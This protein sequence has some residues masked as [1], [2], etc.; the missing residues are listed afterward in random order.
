MDH[1]LRH[2]DQVA[3]NRN[4]DGRKTVT[5]DG[6]RIEIE[7]PCDQ[8]GSFDPQLIAKYQ[9]RFAGFDDKII[10]MCARGMSTREIMDH[11]RDLYGIDGSPD[12]INTITEAVLED[13]AAS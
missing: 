8:A 7:A 1:H 9:R 13:V 5:T 12:L 2:D 11:V 4:D 6:G 10:S 3:N